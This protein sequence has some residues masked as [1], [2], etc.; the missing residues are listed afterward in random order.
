MSR[1]LRG[2]C[3]CGAVS[4]ELEVDEPRVMN[5]YCKDCQRATGSACATFV[6]VSENRL[7][8]KGSPASFTTTG[9]SGRT[10]D[11]FFCAS[12]GSQLWATVE[13]MPGMVF[14]K[15]GVLEDS[16]GL[17]PQSSLWTAS[18]ANWAPLDDSIP[19]FPRSPPRR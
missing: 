13:A 1:Q 9:D 11:R 3:L 2:H 10:V 16:T 12:C 18:A 7:N 17:K 5:C 8:V 14:V 4:F 6:F 15:I 19:S